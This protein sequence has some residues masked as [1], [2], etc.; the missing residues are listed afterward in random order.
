MGMAMSS[1][2]ATIHKSHAGKLSGF[3]PRFHRAV[4]LIGRR[5]TGAVIRALVGGP[6]RFN[7]LLATVPGLSDRLLSERLRELEREH[8]VH[9]EVS[10]GPPVRVEY[11]LTERG[12]DLEPAIRAIAAWAERWIEAEPSASSPIRRSRV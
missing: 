8:I 7:E 11:S 2:Q 5:W 1:G 9:R 3:C 4:E 10:A 6:L 12:A